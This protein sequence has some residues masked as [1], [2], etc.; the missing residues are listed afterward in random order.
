MTDMLERQIQGRKKQ[1]EAARIAGALSE[2][3][4]RKGRRILHFLEEQKWRLLVEGAGS[5]GKNHSPSA[6]EFSCLKEAFDAQTAELR[7]RVNRTK[8]RLDHLFAFV[9][10]AFVEGNEM[11]ILVTELTVRNDSARFIAQF[12]CEAY[13]RHNQELMLSE[14]S[15]GLWE[16]VAALNLEEMS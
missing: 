6:A 12:G 13:H 1:M 5:A 14:R 8:K 3:E 10:N 15:S 11:L 9:E 16:E 7:G 2:R 4:L